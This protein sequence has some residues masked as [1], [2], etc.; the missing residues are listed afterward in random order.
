[1]HI[2]YK[3]SL[4]HK[5]SNVW[6]LLLAALNMTT[7][8]H[9]HTLLSLVQPSFGFESLTTILKNTKKNNRCNKISDRG[10][11]AICPYTHTRM[12]FEN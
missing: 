3:K 1:M 4:Y 8:N 10:R 6:C 11:L 9:R 5:C 7:G 2:I 12:M